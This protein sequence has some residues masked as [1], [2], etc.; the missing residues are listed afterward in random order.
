MRHIQGRCHCGNLEYEF[1]LPAAGPSIPVRACGC[2]FC[3]KHGGVYT[4][5]A[6]GQ[7]RARV[8]DPGRVSRYQFGTKTAEFYICATCGAVPFVISRIDGNDYAVVNVN[9]FENVD[10]AELDSS[11]TDFD[12]EDVAG[13]LDRRRRSWIPSVRITTVD[14]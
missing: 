13:R 3:V 7:L 5:H 6:D 11:A 2:T 14:G 1:L 4:S 9:T 12:A 8:N 10:R